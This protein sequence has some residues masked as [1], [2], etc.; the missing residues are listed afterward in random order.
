MAPGLVARSLERATARIPGIRRIPLLRLL[1]VAEVGMLAR[2]H[3]LR[4][5]PQERRRLFVL[6]RTA[7]GRPSTLSRSERDEFADLVAKREPKLLAS[8]AV[9][10]LSPV[11]LPHRLVHGPRK[12]R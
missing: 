6:V 10:R 8:E 4:L 2:D 12:S 11:P 9:D 3:V 5:T 1:A 7:R